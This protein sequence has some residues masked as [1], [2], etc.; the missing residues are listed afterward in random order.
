[1]LP[2]APALCAGPGPDAARRQ[3]EAVRALGGI[4]VEAAGRVDP[5]ALT[6]LG[7]LSCVLWWGDAETGRAMDRALAARE[8]PL[9]PLVT[10]LPDTGHV[11]AERHVCVD[12]TAAGG[13]AALLS[14]AA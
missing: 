3:A 4:A 6:R 7:E 13:N 14:G 2:G 8:G 11:C 12:T 1:V 5:Q 10:G 9:V